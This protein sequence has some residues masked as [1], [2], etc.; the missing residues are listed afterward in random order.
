MD[1]WATIRW[2][3]AQDRVGSQDSTS[4]CLDGDSVALWTMPMPGGTTLK[5]LKACCAH[6]RSEYRSA[7]VETW[8]A[9]R[10][11]GAQLMWSA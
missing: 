2:P 7:L 10:S 3:S 11:P 1:G 6:F 5:P 4:S 8:K 9:I